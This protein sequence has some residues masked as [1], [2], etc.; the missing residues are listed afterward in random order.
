[1]AETSAALCFS[2]FS[3]I[4]SIS[5]SKDLSTSSSFPSSSIST[6]SRS[7]P[8]RPFRL[9]P[10]ASSDSGN[11]FADD[12]FG[13]FPWSD[14]QT[15]IH[16]VPEGKVTLFTA[17]GLIQIGGSVVPR[18]VSSSEKK[19]VR[20]KTAQR[21]QR[22]QESDY[23]D[24]KQ[25]LCLGALFDIAATNG[26]DMGRRLCIFG[27]CRSIEM[28]SDVVEDTVLENGGE[29]VSAEKASRG[30]LNEKLTMTVA[31]PLLWGVPPASETL[32]LAVQSG[33]GIVEK[34][35][36]QWDFL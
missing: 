32:H 13:F 20:S 17:D 31:V 25:E 27:F 12:S 8:S 29:V 28:L 9:V 33:G 30:G 11:F 35:Y 2:A 6:I 15:E 16:W 21:F 4:P 26:L 14:G 1:M 3:S 24:P 36:W 5:R 7:H 18:R 23:M 34:V 19:Q 22:F 10:R